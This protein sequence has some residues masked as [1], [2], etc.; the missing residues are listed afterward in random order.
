MT[1]LA[2]WTLRY[3]QIDYGCNTDK[4][5]WYESECVRDQCTHVAVETE[6]EKK[7]ET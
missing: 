5:N 2:T 1:R 3:S 4:D 7:V 6:V